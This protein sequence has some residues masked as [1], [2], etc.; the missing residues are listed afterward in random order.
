MKVTTELRDQRQL[1][2]TVE[3]DQ[4]RVDQELRKAARKVSQRYNIP[5]FRKGRVPYSVLVRHVGLPT[6][7]EEF[8]DDLGQEVFREAI[9]QEKIEPYAMAAVEGI[10]FDPLGVQPG[11]T[12]LTLHETGF[13]AANKRCYVF[14]RRRFLT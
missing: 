5:G 8:L 11:R 9:E 10:E 2:L 1:A 12:G 7:Y 13:L 4:E 14:K 3:V 6:L